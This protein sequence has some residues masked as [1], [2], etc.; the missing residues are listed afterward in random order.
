MAFVD[1]PG[2]GEIPVG[3]V[4]WGLHLSGG[5]GG[6]RLGNVVTAYTCVLA[7]GFGVVV[8]GCDGNS[9]ISRETTHIIP[10]Y[11]FSRSVAIGYLP[12]LRFTHQATDTIDTRNRARGIAIGNV[13]TINMP[14]QATHISTYTS[15]R[16][17]CVTMA[18]ARRTIEQT[19]QTTDG[20]LHIVCLAKYRT[21]GIAIVQIGK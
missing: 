4:G 17:G 8:R 16:N 13:R 10:A 6:D 19:H 21:S 3:K 5:E 20:G 1:H 15:N 11:H 7:R 12:R 2:V 18:D 9:I 14:H